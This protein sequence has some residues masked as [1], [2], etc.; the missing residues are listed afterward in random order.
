MMAPMRQSEFVRALID[1]NLPPPSGLVAWNGSDPARRFA[2]YRNNVV[3]SLVAALAAKFPVAKQLV[4][5]EFFL[6]MAR[7]Y[8]LKRPPRSQL[9]MEYGEDF[10]SFISA[11]EHASSL[12]YLADVA[13]LEA[14]RVFAY[15]AAD[16]PALGPA[17]FGFVRLDGLADLTIR[18]HPSARLLVSHFAVVSLWNAH[19]GRLDIGSVDPFH[20]E[21][22]LIVRPRLDVEVT[23]LSAGVALFLER[24]RTGARLGDAAKETIEAVSAFD[25]ADALHGLVATGVA[26]SLLP[27]EGTPA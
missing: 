1:P 11:F 8:V 19:Q 3:A 2:V 21:D 23:R 10:P 20:P 24:V 7:A 18:L 26:T 15:H 13:M 22:A 6:A 9:L 25:L 27:H 4:G 12:P 5:D 17:E 14:A 16:A